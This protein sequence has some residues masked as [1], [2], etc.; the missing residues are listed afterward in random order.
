MGTEI[1]WGK[2][3]VVVFDCDG[4]MFDS[5]QA[6][7]AYYNQLLSHF[8]KP[9]MNIEQCRFVHMHT[10]S[11]SVA[12]IFKD[13]P[14]AQEAEAYRQQMSYFPFVSKMHR[15]PYLK[16]LLAYLR[17][18][19][20]TAIATN[21]SD[22][23]GRVLE[24]HGLEGAFDLVVSCLDVEHPKPAPDALFKILDHFSVSAQ[25]AVYIGDSEIDQ[26][27]AKAARV[28]FI[29]YK[30]R[31][32]SADCHIEHFVKMEAYLGAVAGRTKTIFPGESR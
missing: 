10:A 29:A 5:G 15:E 1:S 23:M 30:N 16:R 2:I 4:V 14:R 28:P 27:T 8:G 20:K 17:P 9:K 22:T 18:S 31:K 12:H 13:D 26:R 24:E 32:L 3:R 7:E 21:R 6:N 19:Y 11:Q 25:E